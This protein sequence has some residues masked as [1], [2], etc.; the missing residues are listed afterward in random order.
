MRV[1]ITLFLFH[2]GNNITKLSFLCILDHHK[3]NHKPEKLHK[4][5]GLDSKQRKYL[6]KELALLNSTEPKKIFVNS[7]HHKNSSKD[8]VVFVST[9]NSAVEVNKA[10]HELSDFTEGGVG[11]TSGLHYQDQY[12]KRYEV[13]GYCNYCI[14]DMV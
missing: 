6:I 3:K 12:T 14:Q 13:N 7:R 1:L 9:S 2:L 10:P 8:F 11:A 5:H 4:K